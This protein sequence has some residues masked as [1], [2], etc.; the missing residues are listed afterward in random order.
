MQYNRVFIA[1]KP[2]LA[3]AIA[4]GLADIAG[5]PMPKR[6]SGCYVI[7]DDVVV[8]FFGHMYE[9]AEPEAY[10]EKW[11][12]WSLASLPIRVKPSE[13]KLC[14]VAD[15]KD[16]IDNIFRIVKSAKVIVNCGD[17]AREGQLLVD[18][19]LVA[20]GID[21][22][23]PTTLRLW[24]RSVAR[25][26]IVASLKS[27]APNSGKRTL[28]DA[29][30]CR[31]RA[32]W[33]VGMNYSRFY[34][35]LA[36]RGGSDCKIT[37]GR[38]QTPTLAIIVDR[39]AERATFKPTDHY[40]PTVECRP[41]FKA[42]WIPRDECD[43]LDSEGRLTDKVIADQL[44][45]ATLDINLGKVSAFKSEQKSKAPPLPYSLSALQA[46]AGSK[47]GLSAK[48]TLDVTQKLYEEYRCVSYPRTD[49]RYLPT[50]LLADVPSVL[51]ALGGVTDL[52]DAA[53]NADSALRSAAWDDKQI[54]DHHGLAVTTEFSAEKFARMSDTEKG[55]FLLIAKTFIAQFHQPFRYRSNTAEVM[56][57]VERFRAIGRTVEAQGWRVVYGAAL[58][59]DEDA[60]APTETVPMMKVGDSV[61]VID[62][63]PVPK[64][65]S[66]PPQFTDGSLITAMCQVHRLVKD[67][68]LKAKLKQ[69]D[70]IGTE[71]TRADCIETLL[72][73]GYVIRKG[74]TGLESTKFGRSIISQMPTDLKDPGL[75][76]L[77]E[78]SLTDV[79]DGKL[80]P[81]DFLATLDK[82]IADRIEASRHGSIK[83]TDA[84]PRADA[85][86]PLPG[87]GGP[88]PKCGKGVMKTKKIT[89]TKDKREVT[90]LSCSFYPDCEHSI[91]PNSGNGGSKSNTDIP[92]IE[93]HGK[94]CPKCGKGKML[95][96]EIT[97]KKDGR[98][99][100]ILS[101]N[102]YP[103]CEHSEFQKSATNP[104]QADIPPLPGHGKPCPKCKSGKMLTKAIKK[105]DGSTVIVLSCDAYKTSGCDNTEWP[106][107]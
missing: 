77:W 15:K 43:G 45:K 12:S 97:S 52:A 84:P 41:A 73:R 47:L 75:T 83:I 26:D 39:D 95:T 10:S 33:S 57:G 11:K 53:R 49:C 38:V 72:K 51:T 99:H 24:V 105:K 74:K 100:V 37:I 18:E 103:A 22:H 82:E 40:I 94:L 17:A 69:S 86:P 27:L 104:A 13:W 93:G 55:V 42:T 106:K 6:S 3:E 102:A 88:C 1:E 81:T 9:Q 30:V 58:P 61:S 2:S 85:V 66:P 98:K 62:T 68:I 34:T 29:A 87:D 25:K 19:S 56:V 44:C 96:K 54:S 67:P 107:R 32:D 71:A 92:P 23:G 78:R 28:Y 31:Q 59:D 63:K 46:E 50:S 90:I 21:P 89:T 4:G 65:T 76:A 16:H 48:E 101:C 91:W 60:D 20:N 79:Q 64:R 36:R 80:Q 8:W 70:G 35:L 7:N 5:V 14:V